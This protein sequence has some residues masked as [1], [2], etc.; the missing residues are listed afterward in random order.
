MLRAPFSLATFSDGRLYEDSAR[1]LLDHP[2]WGTRPFYLQGLYA[3]QLALPMAIRPWISARLSFSDR[4]TS[5]SDMG[6]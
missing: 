6:H 3:A 5:G 2:P 1:D 4:I